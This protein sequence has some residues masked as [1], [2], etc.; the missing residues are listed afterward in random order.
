M[1]YYFFLA[2]SF[3]TA[4][5]LAA[6]IYWGGGGD[7]FSWHDEANWSGGVKPGTD[8]NAI[9]AFGSV[10]I[11]TSEEAKS[12]QVQTKLIVASTG[13]LELQDGSLIASSGYSSEIINYG[14]IFI[15]NGILNVALTGRFVNTSGGSI[16]I[17][18]GVYGIS[19]YGT[20]VNRVNA[21]VYISNATN[22]GVLVEDSLDNRG[23]IQVINSEIGIKLLGSYDP[24]YLKNTGRIEIMD[25]D[26]TGVLIITGRL[27]NENKI[28]TV[29]NS[30][31]GIDNFLNSSAEIFNKPGGRI[32]SKD[33]VRN[34]GFFENKGTLL[35]G[36]LTEPAMEN[37]ADFYNYDSLYISC[38]NNDGILNKGDFINYSNGLILSDSMNS[39]VVNVYTMIRN[40]SSFVNNGLIEAECHRYM[41]AIINTDLFENNVDASV[42]IE[43]ALIG[44]LNEKTFINEG[45]L[46]FGKSE[47]G[48]G[49]AQL[50]SDALFENKG[51]LKISDLGGDIGIYNFSGSILNKSS[52]Q[53]EISNVD[54]FE[55]CIKNSATIINNGSL[56]VDV[57]TEVPALHNHKTWSSFLNR[58]SVVFRTTHKEV[59]GFKNEGEFINDSCATLVNHFA[60][61]NEVNGSIENNGSIAH[62]GIG[63]VDN[64]GVII[65][66][67]FYNS[68]GRIRK[69]FYSNTSKGLVINPFYNP[70]L[71]NI[72]YAPI[73]S[74]SITS[75]FSIDSTWYTDLTLAAPFATFD[76]TNNLLIVNSNLSTS[77]VYFKI[78]WPDI[79]CEKV[80]KVNVLSSPPV[81]DSY[82][83]VVFHNG[84]N[85]NWF[86]RANWSTNTYP[87]YCS[88][89]QV[90]AGET[91]NLFNDHHGTANKIEIDTGAVFDT[92]LGSILDVRNGL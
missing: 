20:F 54:L 56:L 4:E 28:Q 51:L 92:E 6:D 82:D 17:D 33:G 78:K 36:S 10:E 15:S 52:E 65:N 85:D 84:L 75:N 88:N 40:E 2:F 66:N 21:E 73:M 5:L 14:D 34:N 31:G 44:F 37:L 45:E 72:T 27:E 46:F 1:K 50:T 91:L 19:S 80:V 9:I 71:E 11:S 38:I 90:A 74:K 57:S 58:G 49:F 48:E 47:Y 67:G 29:N 23:Y 7:G 22:S 81:C 25:S 26:S 62:F 8:D 69:I 89:I 60:I 83:E 76:S 43:G 53:I 18:G 41:I 77:S 3:F 59:V 68:H 35:L 55:T 16:S 87:D 86:E 70:L 24:A 32:S 13:S 42:K 63:G 61:R 30:G 12:V 79:F 39:T 64:L